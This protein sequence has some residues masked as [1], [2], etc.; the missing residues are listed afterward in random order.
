MKI[1]IE[2]RKCKHQYKNDEEIYKLVMTWDRTE[3]RD[4]INDLIQ[5]EKGR[6]NV[7]HLC[8]IF[9]TQ[10]VYDTTTNI[11]K[12]KGGCGQN[13]YRPSNP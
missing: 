2:K 6:V 4:K 3:S 10:W 11:Y 12:W 8:H 9:I 13:C 7:V 5:L 1:E